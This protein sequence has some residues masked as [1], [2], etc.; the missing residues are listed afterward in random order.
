MTSC[1]S[2]VALKTIRVSA[3]TKFGSQ[4]RACVYL[5]QMNFKANR[6]FE[7]TEYQS[8]QQT[9]VCN[10]SISQPTSYTVCMSAI[11]GHQSHH[12]CVCDKQKI[13]A[14]N[15]RVCYNWV[16]WPATDMSYW[17][18]NWTT[19][20]SPRAGYRGQLVEV[21]KS[22][23][24]NIPWR[25]RDGFIARSLDE[26]TV[27]WSTPSPGRFTPGKDPVPATQYLLKPRKWCKILKEASWKVWVVAFFFG[28]GHPVVS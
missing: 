5:Q 11:N 1:S 22:S 28:R 18:S 15:T 27:Q 17:K 13:K 3:V 21:G 6:V 4:Q 10:Y 16:S 19:I 7:I 24:C 9:C 20:V 26:G 23:S 8:Q 25:H 14:N 12:I 2:S